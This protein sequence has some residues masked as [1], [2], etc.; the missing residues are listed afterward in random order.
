MAA[1][2]T[3]QQRDRDRERVRAKKER[4]AMLKRLAPQVSDINNRVAARLKQAREQAG[5]T[6]RELADQVGITL[7]SQFRREAGECGFAVSDLYLYAGALGWE[8]HQ[9][10]P[11]P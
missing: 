3:R 7:S 2:K 11:K 4:E 6:A 9:L 10:L 5:M 8:P 1:T